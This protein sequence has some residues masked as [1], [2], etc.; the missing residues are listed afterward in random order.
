MKKNAP[1]ESLRSLKV[2]FKSVFIRS[3]LVALTLGFS[4]DT[5]ASAPK[6]GRAA[7]A[8]YF[9]NERRNAGRTNT[10][11]GPIFYDPYEDSTTRPNRRT[12]SAPEQASEPRNVAQEEKSYSSSSSYVSEMHYMSLGFGT[13]SEATA[14]EWGKDGR[15]E[16]IGKWGVE[17]SYR[18]LEQEYLFDESLR[19]GYYEYKPV[20]QRSTK[21][22]F[23]YMITFPEATSKFPLYFG[24]AAGLGVFMEQLKGESAIS[25]DYQLFLGVRLFNVFDSVGF[26]VEGGMRN[27]LHLAS[28]G[29]V[30]GTF[31]SLGT[32]F[33]F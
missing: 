28:D 30:N 4:L 32:V 3:V 1:R 13:F 20:D 2:S 26:Y 31:L 12:A 10:P 9:E 33:T 27:H 29:Q 24:G 25:F 21:L 17:L 19:I 16:K 15:E 22:S 14:F 11:N 7:A 5:L 23:M 18:L 8:R 6:V